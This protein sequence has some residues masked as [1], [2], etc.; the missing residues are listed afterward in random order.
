MMDY[1]QI[2]ITVWQLRVCWCGAFSLTRG[3]VCCLQLLL[4]LAWGSR[5]YFTLSD[6]RLPFSLPPTIRRVTV[7]VFDPASTQ[8]FQSLESQSQS[9]IATDGRSI[10]KSWCRVPSGAHDQIFIT[11]WQLRS[12]FCGA[13]SL[14]RGWVCLLYMLLVL[15]S[16]VFIRPDSLGSC[17]HI[18]LS[19]FWEFPFRRLLPLA[20]SQWRYLTPLMLC[21]S[22]LDTHLLYFILCHSSVKS[23][24]LFVS[25]LILWE[26]QN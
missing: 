6:S 26:V 14:M 5:L 19:Q 8:D 3:W 4:A 17:N 7:E 15:A 11:V 21:F 2:F 20:G 24:I 25:I 13:P 22:I 16:A 18:S 23:R 10:T 9:Y 12:C 1:D